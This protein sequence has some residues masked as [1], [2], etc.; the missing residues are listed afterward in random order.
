MLCFAEGFVI[1][2]EIVWLVVCV[3]SVMTLLI[4]GLAGSKLFRI[5]FLVAIVIGLSWFLGALLCGVIQ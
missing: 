2:M 4:E 3:I 1:L 5:T